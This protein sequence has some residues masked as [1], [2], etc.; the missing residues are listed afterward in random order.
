[1]LDVLVADDDMNVRET[2]AGALRVAGHR[3]V[4]ASDGLD[5]VTQLSAHAFD[6]AIC[7][8]RMPRLDG[9]AL[10]RRI[11]RESPRTS[12]VMMTTYASVSDVVGSLRG[13]AVDYVSKPFDVDELIANIIQPLA[14]RRSIAR[15]FEEA[16][17]GFVSRATGAAIVAKSPAMIHL[18]GRI[19]MLASSDAPVL[20]TGDKGT[21]KELVARTIHAKGPRRD[22]PFVVVD[23][24][25]LLDL[26]EAAAGEELSRARLP[27]DAWFRSAS[28]GTLVIDG[29]ERLPL[30]AQRHLLR[31]VDEPALHAR[32]GP[33]WEPLGV[34][35]LSLSR[36]SLG[37]RVASG[38]LMDSLHYRIHAVHLRV[39]PLRERSDDLFPLVAE[40][41]R[42]LAPPSATSPGISP[43]AWVALSRHEFAGNVRELRWALERALL[44][45][46]GGEI[47]EVHLPAHI[48]ATGA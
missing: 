24:S 16:R 6:V 28:G 31:L 7:D 47:D 2:V 37:D 14:E 22:G 35:L 48:V 23:G 21:G 12:V 38:E 15:R 26:M 39:P 8:V 17:D 36:E 30:R 45:S 40:L 25:E 13:G 1:M 19:T 33:D 5:A 9:H 34:R 43:R 46:E 27:Q 3:V 18:S 41:L 10:L 44:Q 11:R 20:I 29:I 42:E 32:R 4:E